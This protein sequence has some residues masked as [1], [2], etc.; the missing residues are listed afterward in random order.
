MG[1]GM[2]VLPRPGLLTTRV[3]QALTHCYI[4]NY[5]WSLF[6]RTEVGEMLNQETLEPAVY[7]VPEIAVLLNINRITAYQLA[8][9]EGFP[10]V[11]IGRRI[12][13]PKQAFHRWLDRQVAAGE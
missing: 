11:R 13:V 2:T 6:K 9:K 10:A 5:Y 4:E 3:S 7:D 12:I 8:K 1:L